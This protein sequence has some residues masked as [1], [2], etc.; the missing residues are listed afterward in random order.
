MCA[1]HHV[2]AGCRHLRQLVLQAINS[3]YLFNTGPGE[4]KPD[5]D[6]SEQQKAL[7]QLASQFESKE[8]VYSKFLAIGLFRYTHCQRH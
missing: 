4:L 1:R 6:G 8:A 5:A 7:A 3:N 2:A